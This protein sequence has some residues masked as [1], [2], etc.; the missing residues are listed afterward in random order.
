MHVHQN[1][2]PWAP[3][4][5]TDPPG[6]LTAISDTRATDAVLRLA[7]LGRATIEAAEA[8]VTVVAAAEV[9]GASSASAAEQV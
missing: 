5:C 1:A 9:A 4:A 3:R 2:W 7:F 8:P 6:S